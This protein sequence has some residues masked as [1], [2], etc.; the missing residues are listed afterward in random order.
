MTYQFSII[1]PTYKRKKSLM[2]L[3]Q[4]LLPELTMQ[5]EVIVVEQ[6]I[7][8][9]TT[10]KSFAKKH[11]IN[12]HY[13]FLPE[14]S[15][16]HAKNVGAGVAKG[17]Y[18]IFFD[19]DVVVEKGILAG[20]KKAFLKDDNDVVAG[21]V[22]TPGHPVN[23]KSKNIGK[24]SY[25]GKFSDDYT[26]DIKQEV[27]TVIGC[28]AGWKREVFEKVGG[29]DEQIT[30]NG[31]REESDLSLRAKALGFKIFF[32]PKAAVTH[33]REAT[34]GGRKSEG[35]L[36][37][38]YNFL[39]N[40]TYFF[41][42]YRPKWV[43]GIILLTRWEWFVRCMFGF[44]REVSMRSIRTPFAGVWY[45]IQ[46][47][48]KWKKLEKGL[49]IGVDAGC[50]GVKDE[51]LKVGVYQV[52]KNVMQELADL[53]QKNHYILYSF[54]PIDKKLMQRLGLQFRNIIVKPS[55][56]WMKIWLPL[57]LFVDKPD[58]FIGFSQSLPKRLPG[59]NYRSLVLLYDLAYER[60]PEFYGDYFRLQKNTSFAVLKADKIL[61]ISQFSKKDIVQ[62]YP[63]TQD[64]IEA[65][66]LGVIVPQIVSAYKPV[67][68]YFL[69]VGALKPAKNLPTVLRAFNLFSSMSKKSYDLL[70]VGGDKWLD[71]NIAVEF[72]K[73][74]KD[75]Q[76]K[77]Y[78]RGVVSDKKLWELYKGAT[79]LLMPSLY[80]GFGLPALEAMAIG[81][82]VIASRV[83]ALPEVV[84]DAGCLVTS[85]DEKSLA[86]YMKLV[87][88]D[89]TMRNQL[90]QKGI[91]RAK[92]FSWVSFATQVL[93]IITS[94]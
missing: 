41:L 65:G 1:I 18:L 64:K 8:N 30:M 77:I 47:Y 42:K 72:A 7:N 59:S 86:Q 91:E 57:R 73:L 88:T 12:L 9:G 37:W 58:V 21:K 69:F 66:Y 78:F 74:P 27:D 11:N 70:V 16:P 76:K 6:V 29:F 92:T 35:R 46:K 3:L 53:D 52:A 26:S 43:V 45:G 62:Q 28:N 50:L 17:K 89:S 20:Y 14:A 71:T 22:L 68:P 5:V 56:G 93:D 39:S 13:I 19:D 15:T 54:Y 87:V 33:L 10:L 67:R 80:E 61:T 32:E 79:A 24:I 60:F 44:G 2:R 83:G 75:I 82:P 25:F 34:G 85:E 63:D 38:Y 49:V 4:S 31:I 81:C 55:R 90:K 84:G 94:L 48:K 51:R 36:K 40:D 23:P